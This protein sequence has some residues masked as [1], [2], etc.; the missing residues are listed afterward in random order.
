MRFNAEFTEIGSFDIKGKMRVSDPC[1]SPDVWCTGVLDAKPG[2]WD[3]AVMILDNEA[4]AG[5][6]ERVAILAAKH[7]NCLITMDKETINKV[8]GTPF[9]CGSED[10]KL[11]DFEVGVDSGQAGFYDEENFVA[12]NGGKDDAWYDKMCDITLSRAKANTFSDGV[13]SRSGYGDGGYPCV[14]HTN[15]DGKADFAFVIFIGEGEEE[16]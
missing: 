10:W 1:Y 13:V 14:Y 6:G 16:F 9:L 11:A 15:G 2:T 4:T 7:E 5:W 3:A 8:V 12:H